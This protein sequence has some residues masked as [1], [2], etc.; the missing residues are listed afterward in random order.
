MMPE[1]S[2][3][4]DSVGVGAGPSCGLGVMIYQSLWMC[5]GAM[6]VEDC[7]TSWRNLAGGG[8]EGGTEC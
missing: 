1:E 5:T 6:L 7:H 8:T 3:V 2:V 4:V